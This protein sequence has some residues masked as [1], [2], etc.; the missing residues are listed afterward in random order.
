L[1]KDSLE[2]PINPPPPTEA[3]AIEEVCRFLETAEITAC[4]LLLRG[5]N[6]VF[7]V[8]LVKGGKAATAVYKPRRG[9]APLWDF[10]DGS[11]YKRE[12][13]AFLL[14]G[15]LAWSLV[16][17][18]VVRDG[19]WGIG[20]VQ[21][22]VSV[23]R[24]FNFESRTGTDLFRLKQV[25]AFD[26]LVNNAD[27]KAGHFLEG[28]DGHLW[29][30]DHG[31]TFNAEPKLRTVLWDFAGQ[32]VPK[33]LVADIAALRRKLGPGSP[34]RNALE[35]WIDRSEIAALEARINKLIAKPVFT[36]P[37]SRWSVPWPWW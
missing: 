14:S 35:R 9:E 10:P 8:K 30:V 29:V 21:W 37:R 19:P 23:T 1:D 4:D 20:S 22:F 34:L 7:V 33:E 15:A 13:A 25:A 27:R 32:P 17:P 5:S 26:H 36:H 12:Y 3:A 28:S 11:L 18:T 31:L 16:P 2:Y 6:H 24:A